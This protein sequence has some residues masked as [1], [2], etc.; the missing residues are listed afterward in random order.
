MFQIKIQLSNFITTG[1]DALDL[2]RRL[3][4][5]DRATIRTGDTPVYVEVSE[6]FARLHFSRTN[7]IMFAWVK[8]D[9]LTPADVV[10]NATNADWV[11]LRKDM[12]AERVRELFVA[13]K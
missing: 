2:R 1:L 5:S 12:P 7:T 13:G 3:G 10:E 9:N 4:L 11:E 8:L 6:G